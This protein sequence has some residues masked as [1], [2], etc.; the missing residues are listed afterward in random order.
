ML[1]YEPGATMAHG[2]DP[3]SKLLAQVGFAVAAFSHPTPAVMGLLTL[4]ALGCLAAA[5]LSPLRVLRAAW[6]LLVMLLVAAGLAAMTLG[7]PWLRPARAADSLRSSYRVVLVLFV[8]GA[9]VRSTPVRD[10]RA[11]IQRHVPGRPGQLLGVGIALVYRFLPVLQADLRS[12]RDAIRARGGQRRSAVDRARYI[13]RGG[14]RRALRR[15]DRLAIAL[16][17]RCFAWNPT[18][19]RLRFGRLDYA[20]LGMGLALALSPLL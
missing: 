19:P 3:R 1:T 16:R 8:A 5:R 2:L 15:A 6:F 7:D 18:L 12:V 17:A 13:V 14:L 11:A 20:V 9:Y 4:V 10:T